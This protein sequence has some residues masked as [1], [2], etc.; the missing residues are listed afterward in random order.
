MWNKVD[1]KIVTL[2]P[3]K[4]KLYKKDYQEF[5]QYDKEYQ[6]N[7]KL[8]E[9]QRRKMK[10]MSKPNPMGRKYFVG[11]FAVKCTIQTIYEQI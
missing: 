6:R 10:A 9:T 4:E 2:L 8:P 3:Q 1:S 5:K 11:E 7:L